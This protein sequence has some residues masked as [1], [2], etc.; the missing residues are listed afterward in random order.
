MAV[1]LLRQPFL[2]SLNATILLNICLVLLHYCIDLL[3]RYPQGARAKVKQSKDASQY[4]PGASPAPMDSQGS[5]VQTAWMEHAPV[6]KPNSI[7]SDSG[8]Y[9]PDHPS[10]R[11]PFPGAS[12]MQVAWNTCTKSFVARF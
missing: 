12:T 9:E 3:N 10:D 1:L 4:A 11:M 8:V 5:L 6:T 7:D 2:A